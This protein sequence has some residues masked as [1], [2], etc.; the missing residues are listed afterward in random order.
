MLLNIKFEI[1]LLITYVMLHF[2]FLFSALAGPLPHVVSCCGKAPRT[3]PGS[4][5]GGIKICTYM[6]S[7]FAYYLF[8]DLYISVSFF[9]YRQDYLLYMLSISIFV[10]H[11]SVF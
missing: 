7:M 10:Y 11:I 1:I 6:S 2:F 4:S 9:Q 8:P 3:L 5:N